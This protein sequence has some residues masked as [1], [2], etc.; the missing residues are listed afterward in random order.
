MK[1]WKAATREQHWSFSVNSQKEQFLTS[2]HD[3]LNV[4]VCE[5]PQT[6]PDD[7]ANEARFLLPRGLNS[8]NVLCSLC[9]Q[10]N[11]KA[12]DEMLET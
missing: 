9:L 8:S 4:L 2:S 3:R 7:V 12:R 6:N 10:L 11:L 1:Q 5:K